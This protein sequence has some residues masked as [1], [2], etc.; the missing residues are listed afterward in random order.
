MQDN[1]INIYIVYFKGTCMYTKE[2][3]AACAL[4]QTQ[5]VLIRLMIEGAKSAELTCS[6]H[7]G[8]SRPTCIGWCFI[9]G[10]TIC[11]F[12]QQVICIYVYII[13]ARTMTIALPLGTTV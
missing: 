11:M 10:V 6:Y 7:F 4:I 1:V 2:N 12:G 5:R 13:L 9:Y 8:W 3:V